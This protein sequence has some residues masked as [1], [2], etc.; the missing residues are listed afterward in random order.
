MAGRFVWSST[1]DFTGRKFVYVVYLLLG[2]VLYCLIPFSGHTGNA[3]IVRRGVRGHFEHVRWRVLHDSGLL[4]GSLWVD[5]GR[6][7]SR[8]AADGMVG[9]RRPWPRPGELHP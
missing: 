7:N 1:S 3:F 8:P 9:C 6:R 4:E 2:A 5:A